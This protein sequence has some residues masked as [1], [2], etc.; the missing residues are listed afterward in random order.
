MAWCLLYQTSGEN[1]EFQ[2]EDERVR[3]YEKEAATV[4]HEYFLSD[5]I[6]KF[7]HSLEDLGAPEYNSLF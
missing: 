1:G 5:D 4:I 2:V 3:K 7:I 6:P